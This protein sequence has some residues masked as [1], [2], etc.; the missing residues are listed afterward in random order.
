MKPN[1]THKAYIGPMCFQEEVRWA[2][3]L[4]DSNFESSGSLETFDGVE[5]FT[6]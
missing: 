2:E 5:D 4:C 1:L 6:W 3:L